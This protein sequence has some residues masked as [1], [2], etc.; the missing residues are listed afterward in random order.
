LLVSGR[1]QCRGGGRV[2][3][4]VLGAVAEPG[5]AR[6]QG[7]P[8]PRVLARWGRNF[9][10]QLRDGAITE[11]GCRSQSSEDSPFMWVRHARAWE[12]EVIDNGD[13]A[14]WTAAHDGYTTLDPPALHR[15]SVLLDRASRS[16]DIIDEIEGSSHDPRLAFHLGPDVQVELNGF[17]ALLKWPSASGLGVARLELPPRLRW[18][19]HRGERDPI[20]G[21]Y[22]PGLGQRVPSFSVVGCGRCVSGASLAT[23]LEFLGARRP[24]QAAAS[25]RVDYV[26]L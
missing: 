24:S 20:I 23:R 17:C 8:P 13:I 12:A 6:A 10:G 1:R 19:L 22:S 14:R 18:T 25:Q 15:R 5:S 2:L 16:I 11:L 3:M 7:T 21:R 26:T 9:Y 4:A